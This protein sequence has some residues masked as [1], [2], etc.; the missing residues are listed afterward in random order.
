MKISI[1]KIGKEAARNQLMKFKAIVENYS[2]ATI[3]ELIAKS[4]CQ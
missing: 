2:K 3:K 4:M 1:K